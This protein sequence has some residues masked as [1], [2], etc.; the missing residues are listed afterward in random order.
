MGHRT[1]FYYDNRGNLTCVL[2]PE[3]GLTYYEYDVE[4]RMTSVKNPWGE[5]IYYEYDPGARMTKEI[6]GNGTLAYYEYD[7]VGRVSKL[8]SRKSDL[9]AISAFEYARDALG[10]PISILRED[11]CQPETRRA[12]PPTT[13]SWAARKAA[14]TASPM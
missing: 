9:T 11:R 7:A 8:E 6:P 12:G 2:D 10:N 3:N 5:A 14:P 4:N 1:A 13:S